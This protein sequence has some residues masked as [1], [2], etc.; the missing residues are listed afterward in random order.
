MS[1]VRSK[2]DEFFKWMMQDLAVAKDLIK[3]W[4]SKDLVNQLD[5]DKLNIEEGSYVDKKLRKSESDILFSVKRKDSEEEILLYILCE[6]QSSA[7]A[8]MPYRLMSYIMKILDRYVKTNK[9]QPLPLPLVYPFVVYN[10]ET[11]WSYEKSFS[12]LFGKSSR[13]AKN[14]LTSDF[15]VLDV[16]ELSEAD[17]RRQHISNLMLASLKRTKGHQLLEKCH[18]LRDL[19]FEHAIKP[20]SDTAHGVLEYIII[21]TEA[22]HEALEQL[23]AVLEEGFA[24]EYEEVIMNLQQATVQRTIQ[25]K[26]PDWIQQGI[27]QDRHE[28][29][30]RMIRERVE[31]PL[32]SKITD[33][34]IMELENIEREMRRH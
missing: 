11:K 21:A 28:M 26:A 9:E 24:P 17:L 1:G 7:D 34:S 31:F 3:T 4:F 30:L 10:G 22:D 27:Q 33:F 29:A 2:H 25:E 16:N 8:M 18:L 12:G 6:H 32:I 13:L 19:F 15:P 23:W 20:S 14:V 5:L